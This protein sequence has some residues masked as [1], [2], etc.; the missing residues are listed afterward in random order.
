M[1]KVQY[2]QYSLSQ[3]LGQEDPRQLWPDTTLLKGNIKKNRQ[4]IIVGPPGIKILAP[5]L[6]TQLKSSTYEESIPCGA[7]IS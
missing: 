6:L 4:P 7:G 5:L 1:A 2:L 3:W